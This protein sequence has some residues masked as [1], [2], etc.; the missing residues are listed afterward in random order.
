MRINAASVTAYASTTHCSPVR[1][2]WS[3]RCTLGSAT[4][5]IVMSTSSM[6]VVAQTATSVQRLAVVGSSICVTPLVAERQAPLAAFLYSRF[7]L[8]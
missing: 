5:T 6:N 3:C 8:W 7:Q 4:F 1:L 2:A